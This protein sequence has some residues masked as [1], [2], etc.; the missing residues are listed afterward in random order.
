MKLPPSPLILRRTLLTAGLAGLCTPLAACVRRVTINY[1]LT[2]QIEAYG[3]HY[4]G[5]SVQQIMWRD[6][7]TE[8]GSRRSSFA[9]NL[10][11][12]VVVDLADHGVVAS[13]FVTLPDPDDP[14]PPYDSATLAIW[15]GR[16]PSTRGWNSVINLLAD[17]L[18]IPRAADA[19]D[20]AHLDRLAALET[21]APIPVAP[22]ELPLLVWFPNRNDPASVRRLDA[23]RSTGPVIL[24]GATLQL[25]ESPPTTGVVERSLPWV[26]PYH[27]QQLNFLGGYG[28]TQGRFGSKLQSEDIWRYPPRK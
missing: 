7:S 14:P 17:G 26:T 10:G 27:Q 16:P 18:E 5:S 12:G 23:L 3:R 11:E 28:F 22:S 20:R 25:V 4:S 2:L 24:I 19:G 21:S 9:G 13:T 8:L 6:F 15:G 1:R